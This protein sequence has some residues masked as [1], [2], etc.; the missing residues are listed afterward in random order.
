MGA[1]AMLASLSPNFAWALQVPESDPRI[2]TEWLD[3]PSPKG[4]G[5]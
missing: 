4:S 2:K 1:A 5:R 3:Y